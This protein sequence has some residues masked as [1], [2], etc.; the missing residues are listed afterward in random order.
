MRGKIKTVPNKV[1]GIWGNEDLGGFLDVTE[2]A[3]S[4]CTRPEES[5]MRRSYCMI[6]NTMGVAGS[7]TARPAHQS[8]ACRVSESN[9][10]CPLYHHASA[11]A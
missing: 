1:K 5:A 11:R 9:K 8:H 10:E 3:F 6:A 2:V 4:V 7:F